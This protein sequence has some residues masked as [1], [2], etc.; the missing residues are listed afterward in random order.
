MAFHRRFQ[1]ML[2]SIAGTGLTK[3]Q[4]HRTLAPFVA[5]VGDAHTAISSGTSQDF[6]GIPLLFY[7]VEDRLYV[8]GVLNPSHKSWF[9]SKLISVEGVPFAQI[10]QRTQRIRAAENDYGTLPQLS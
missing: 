3:N 2:Q 8:A 6:G 4:F 5:S 7:V 1:A 10:F 9:G